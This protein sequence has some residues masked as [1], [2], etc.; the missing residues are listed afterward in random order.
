MDSCVSLVSNTLRDNR[1]PHLSC[2][3]Q[4][5]TRL[6]CDYQWFPRSCCICRIILWVIQVKY[7]YLWALGW[8]M[9][10]NGQSDRR[11]G[12]YPFR[13]GYNFE[14]IQIWISWPKK[15]NE[16]RSNIC[17]QLSWCWWNPVHCSLY[18]GCIS[19]ITLCTSSYHGNI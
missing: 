4:K 13:I 6:M 7:T 18:V 2:K 14:V 8:T 12:I 17:I 16:Y 3:D 19:F 5:K 1:I 11:G 10:D 15:V 9:P